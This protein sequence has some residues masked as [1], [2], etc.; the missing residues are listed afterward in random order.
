MFATQALTIEVGCRAAQARFANLLRGN[1]LAEVS[2]AAYDGGV[3]G[4]LRVG[5]AMPAAK[6]VRVR[7]LDPVYRGDVMRVGLRWEATGPAGGMFPVLDADIAISPG[8]EEGTAAAGESA[9]LALTGAYR[10]PLGRLG[11]GL[12]QV[13]LHRVATATM[14]QLLSSIAATI[15]HPATGGRP[16]EG[17]GPAVRPIPESGMPEAAGYHPLAVAGAA[18]PLGQQGEGLATTGCGAQEGAQR[19]FPLT[20]ASPIGK[21]PIG[22][23]N[24]EPALADAPERRA[25]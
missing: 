24:F 13:V 12:D 10:P 11:A 8:G 21:L 18:T 14:R 20:S 1:W 16:A 19:T 2:E 22:S 23:C 17:T 5:P 6:L 4:L 15:T 9:R 25:G 3:T 7:F